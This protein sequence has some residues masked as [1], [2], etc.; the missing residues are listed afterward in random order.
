MTLF[1]YGTVVWKFDASL[2]TFVYSY[3]PD[4]AAEL[5][6]IPLFSTQQLWLVLCLTILF[7]VKKASLAAFKLITF[8]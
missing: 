7:H 8:H 1:S 4:V 2:N 6:I 5:D 3:S